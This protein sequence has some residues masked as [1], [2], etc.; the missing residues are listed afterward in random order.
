V[1]RTP[2]LWP[3]GALDLGSRSSS[4]RPC[5]TSRLWTGGTA[6]TNDGHAQ[7]VP[8]ED[9]GGAPGSGPGRGTTPGRGETGGRQRSGLPGV[10]SRTGQ[11]VCSLPGRGRAYGSSP[12]LRGAQ[13]PRTAVMLQNPPR[14]V[15]SFTTPAG[16]PG[17]SP[18]PLLPLASDA[19][20]GPRAATHSRARTLPVHHNSDGDSRGRNRVHHP[21]HTSKPV[22]GQTPTGTSTAPPCGPMRRSRPTVVGGHEGS[23]P[24]PLTTRATTTSLRTCP[25]T[26]A[27]A[28]TCPA[29]AAAHRSQR[30]G[31]ERGQRRSH[32]GPAHA[33][34]S[35][36]APYRLY[37]AGMGGLL[38]EHI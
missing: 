37:E 29:W 2:R 1:L 10:E 17:V 9:S 7:P 19:L 4:A 5:P 27:R 28:S 32:S 12:V 36:A 22:V 14:D 13:G 25:V 8:V 3:V 30:E 11:G 18:G 33:P 35:R 20:S 16:R 31:D 23:H 15:N 26:P 6:V 24:P 38:D 34:I 21:R